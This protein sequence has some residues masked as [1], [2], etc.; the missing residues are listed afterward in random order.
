MTSNLSPSSNTNGVTP[1]PTVPI[2]TLKVF[3]TIVLTTLLRMTKFKESPHMLIEASG[4]QPVLAGSRV[5]VA[6]LPIPHT[7]TQSSIHPNTEAPYLS[8]ATHPTQGRTVAHRLIY[9]ISSERSSQMHGDAVTVTSTVQLP[10]K[11]VTIHLAVPSTN[12]EHPQAVTSYRRKA[13]S[14][15]LSSSRSIEKQEPELPTQE[16]IPEMPVS[17]TGT[18]FTEEGDTLPTNPTNLRPYQGSTGVIAG[19]VIG[20]IGLLGGAAAL[21]I[22]YWD[23]LKRRRKKKRSSMSGDI[24]NSIPRRLDLD[25]IEVRD[26]PP[27]VTRKRKSRMDWVRFSKARGLHEVFELEG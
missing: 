27:P 25:S 18:I 20:G 17:A 10:Q 24:L 19:S 4:V 13:I 15:S 5:P 14:T 6:R 23:R 2:S 8:T 3:N 1:S 26:L 9:K 7:T 22:I 11:T 16:L 21:L 12:T